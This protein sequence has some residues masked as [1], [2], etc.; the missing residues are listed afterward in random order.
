LHQKAGANEVIE[1]HGTLA[2]LTCTQCYKKFEYQ[3]LS[4]NLYRKQSIAVLSHRVAQL[5]KPDVILFGEQLPQ[6]AWQQAQ[7][8]RESVI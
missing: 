3:A 4:R 6:K 7:I 5:L 8:R 2:T 1:M